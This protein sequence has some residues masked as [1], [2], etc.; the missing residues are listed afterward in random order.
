MSKNPNKRL[1]KYSIVK[2]S[3]DLT[4]TNKN[5]GLIKASDIQ[6]ASLTGSVINETYSKTN[7]ITQGK[8]DI[9][10]TNL[11][12]ISTIE[13]I[14]KNLII[15]AKDNI[16]NIGANLIAKDNLL[17]QTQNGDVNLQAIKSENGHN[18]Y[19]NGGFDKAKDVEYQTS[20]MMFK[21]V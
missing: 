13:A 18:L 17:L 12:K 4:N 7:T 2:Q 6:I 15:Q 9:T 3:R 5:G 8:N 20:K 21:S 1:V 14:N 19:F 11:G 16:T 10:Y